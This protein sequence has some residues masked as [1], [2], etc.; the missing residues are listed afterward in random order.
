M[1]ILR[2]DHLY[3]VFV[4]LRGAF[5]V[6]LALKPILEDIVIFVAQ[7]LPNWPSVYIGWEILLLFKVHLLVELIILIS[8]SSLAR[9]LWLVVRLRNVKLYRVQLLLDFGVVLQK[10]HGF[11][12]NCAGCATR[13]ALSVSVVFKGCCGALLE[14]VFKALHILFKRFKL[15]LLILNFLA[16]S[17]LVFKLWDLSLEIFVLSILRHNFVL[18]NFPLP[19]EDCLQFRITILKTRGSELLLLLANLSYLLKWLLCCLVFEFD[20]LKA[21]SKL[22]NLSIFTFHLILMLLLYQKLSLNLLLDSILLIWAYFFQH[23]K[24]T[25]MFFNYFSLDLLLNVFTSWSISRKKLNIMGL[26]LDCLRLILAQ[27]IGLFHFLLKFID[28]LHEIKLL[29]S[30]LNNQVSVFY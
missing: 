12:G 19:I 23:L 9:I 24:L 8:H 21:F 4:S 17:N 11:V 1:D 13:G 10:D 16:L 22:L 2:D 26:F 20:T 15:N 25:E 30:R 7:E 18:H 28:L 6:I 3:F 5:W 14:S 27:T 29:V